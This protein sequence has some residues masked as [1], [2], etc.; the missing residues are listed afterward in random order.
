[1]CAGIL[2]KTNAHKSHYLWAHVS[3]IKRLDLRFHVAIHL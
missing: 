3:V 1:M 2:N